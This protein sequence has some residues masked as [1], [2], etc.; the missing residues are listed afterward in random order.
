MLAV[1][2][3]DPEKTRCALLDVRSSSPLWQPMASPESAR[4]W[5]AIAAVSEYSVAM[6]GGLDTAGKATD[7]ALLYDV[8]ADRWSERA[9]WRLRAPSAEHCA[10]V[11][12]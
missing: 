7:T 1:Q 12:E 4:S 5:Q 9:K 10:A 6:L 11:I 2:L 8:R 3:D